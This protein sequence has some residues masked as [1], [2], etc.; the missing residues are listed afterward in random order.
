MA[1]LNLIQGDITQF[2]GDA[3]VNAANTGLV[4]GGGVD[5]AIHR[6][7][8]PELDIACRKLHGCP[9]GEAKVTPG[10]N[11]PVKIIIHTAGPIWRDG[12]FEEPKLLRNC[13]ENSLKRAV[14]NHCQTVAFPSISTGIYGYPLDKA[15]KIGVST[16][17][18]FEAALQVTMVAF[19]EG[20][21]R[22]FEKAMLA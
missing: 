7:A 5:G 3:I 14:E 16:I 11:L 8:G 15:C 10:F 9:T 2:K 18:N 17:R 1:D 4:G 20:T 19:D 21:Y 6:A 13:Y 22:A 12:S